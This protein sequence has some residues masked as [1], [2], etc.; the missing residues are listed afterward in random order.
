M[1][2]I[3]KHVSFNGQHAP[4]DDVES[5]AREL[6]L[7]E[8]RSRENFGVLLVKDLELEPEKRYRVDVASRK[9]VTE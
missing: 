7:S 3:H 8:G 2:H 1:F 4:D 5:K 9:L 6:L